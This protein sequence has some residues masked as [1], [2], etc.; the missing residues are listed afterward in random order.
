M[1]CVIFGAGAIGKAVAGYVFNRLGASI[2]FI[3]ASMDVVR[4]ITKRHGYRIYSEHN[5]VENITGVS[6]FM[7][8]SDA[9]NCALLNADCIVTAVGSNAIKYVAKDIALARKR[10]NQTGI[11]LFENDVEA[12]NTIAATLAENG[13]PAGNIYKASIE[14]MSRSISYDGVFDVFSE[15]FIPVILENNVLHTYPSLDEPQLFRFV[16]SL[17]RFYARKL[18]TNNMGHAVAGFWGTEQGC[19]TLYEAMHNPIVSNKVASALSETA[20]M[21]VSEYGFSFAEM[22]THVA[23]LINHRYCI[24]GMDDPLERL[25]RDPKRKLGND[26]RLV[27]AANLCLKNGISPDTIV[28][29]IALAL[30]KIKDDMSEQ[31][32]ICKTCGL[33]RDDKLTLMIQQA[34]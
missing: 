27:G 33:K 26:E 13:L 8:G 28:E 24:E 23:D 6:A 16:D 10:Q 30:H 14:R 19:T 1:N 32:L 12:K 21:M 5:S 17:E 20:Q 34:I 3:D 31:E 18:Y 7:S 4:D 25:I 11:F 15:K 29:T 2:S 22:D 9:A